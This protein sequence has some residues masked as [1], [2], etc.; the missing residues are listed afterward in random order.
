MTKCKNLEKYYN[1]Y[2]D[3]YLEISEEF[4]KCIDDNDNIKAFQKY[5]YLENKPYF[6]VYLR[7]IYESEIEFEV[8]VFVNFENF[9]CKDIFV[10]IEEDNVDAEEYFNTTF[11]EK[12]KKQEHKN[13][14]QFILDIVKIA[15]DDL[16]F[17]IADYTDAFFLNNHNQTILKETKDNFIERTRARINAPIAFQDVKISVMGLSWRLCFYQ[18][19]ASAWVLYDIKPYKKD[20]VHNN[21][22]LIEE[23]N[24]YFKTNINFRYR[25]IKEVMDTFLEDNGESVIKINK[26]T[27]EQ[28]KTDIKWKYEIIKKS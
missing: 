25:D 28:E 26:K 5:N 9:K 18:T 22:D 1:Q 2:E 20:K 10:M 17:E 7:G 14:Q 11:I 16:E 15:H 4:Q 12:I 8:V 6:M 24:W 21:K 23:L 27:L 19:Y 13:A 3:L